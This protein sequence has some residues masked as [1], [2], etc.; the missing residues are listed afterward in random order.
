[1]TLPE[2]TQ[3]SHYRLER[4]I[5]QGGMGAVHQAHD[6]TLGRPVAIKI[7]HAHYAS[8]PA[9]Q[10]RFAQEARAIAQLDHPSI[11]KVHDFGL[12]AGLAYMVMEYVSGGSLAT[13]LGQLEQANQLLHLEESLRL[14][15]QVAEALGY[16]HRRGMVHRDVKPDNIL[17]KPLDEPPA[18]ETL[19]L[20]VVVTDFGLVKLLNA[21]SATQPGVFM[22]TLAYMA[23]EQVLEQ[24]VDGRADLYALGVI[25]YQLTTGHL[26]F[27]PTSP[28][29]AVLKHL[30]TIPPSPAAVRP[31][32][33]AMVVGLIETAM[34]REPERRYQTGEALAR[35]MRQVADRLQSGEHPIAAPAGSTISLMTQLGK[36]TPAGAGDSPPSPV[37]PTPPPAETAAPPVDSSDVSLALNPA[38]LTIAPGLTA[39]AT[40]TV[41]Q[42]AG[43]P[44]LVTLQVSGVPETWVQ[45]TLTN[46]GL[47]TGT[48]LVIPLTVT[49]PPDAPLPA[50]R[51]AWAIQALDATTGQLVGTAQ[52]WFQTPAQAAFRVELLSPTVRPGQAWEVAIHNQGNT[53]G[54]YSVHVQDSSD[55]VRSANQPPLEVAPGAQ[56]VV[57]LV[58]ETPHS[59]PLLGRTRRYPFQVVVTPADAPPATAPRHPFAG[60]TPLLADGRAGGGRPAAV[61]GVAGSFCPPTAAG[62]RRRQCHAHCRSNGPIDGDAGPCAHCH[63]AP[64][65]HDHPHPHQP[66]THPGHHPTR[67]RSARDHP[68]HPGWQAGGLEQHPP[69]SGPLHRLHHSRLGWQRRSQRCL[70]AG[71]G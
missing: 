48:P 50:G 3:I 28:T 51:Q 37:T 17:L 12:E 62:R 66:A 42:T 40:L 55:Q 13:Y 21:A 45:L 58:L 52:G 30:H 25:L 47:E 53:P 32:L 36:R 16:A 34:A 14:L 64:Y 65:R 38:L 70:A 4:L 31:G 6:L 15:A 9:F 33:P 2:G 49:I 39:R 68:P 20:R 67:N 18:G 59:H 19:P 44:R 22:G 71:L 57:R 7:L 63:N 10:E 29:D 5:G 35:A 8:Q 60:S 46:P 11:V 26:P 24:G 56:G 61:V 1:M 54:R 43:A 41:T 27:T 69:L 23:P